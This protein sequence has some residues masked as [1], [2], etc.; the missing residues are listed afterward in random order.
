MKIGFDSGIGGISV[1]G[2]VSR[3]LPQYQVLINLSVS[4]TGSNFFF[5]VFEST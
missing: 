1:L 5:E 3:H 4:N 2:S